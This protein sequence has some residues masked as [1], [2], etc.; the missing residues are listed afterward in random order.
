[1]IVIE[2]LNTKYFSEKAGKKTLS[3]ADLKIDYGDFVVVMGPPGSGKA[4][5][6]SII[7]MLMRPDAGSY[8]FHGIDTMVLDE[9]QRR[10]LRKKHIG[11]LSHEM[12]LVNEFTVSGN[13]AMPLVYSGDSPAQKLRKVE[14]FLNLHELSIYRD[15]YPHQL[16]EL[17]RLKSG[18]GKMILSGKS[19]LIADNLGANFSPSDQQA[20]IE[21]LTE[22]NK[23]GISIILSDRSEN[24]RINGCRLIR[25]LDGICVQAGK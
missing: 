15:H 21:W 8:H 23:T 19:L 14:D 25:V 7:A 18:V 2:N 9:D 10:S 6:L 5:F 12:D 1:M 4:A 17:A 11:W 22:L 3:V 24:L 20:A 16:D 13:L